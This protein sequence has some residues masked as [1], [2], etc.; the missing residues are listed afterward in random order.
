MSLYVPPQPEPVAV[1]S[2]TVIPLV[3]AAGHVLPPERLFPDLPDAELTRLLTAEGTSEPMAVTGFAILGAD[4][5]ILVDTC[6]GGGKQGRK[7]PFP[8]FTSRWMDTL[9]EAGIAPDAV[10][11]VVNTHLH[12]DHV[13]WN[14]TDELKPT[15]PNARYLL[16][17]AEYEH[18]GT[19]RLRHAD[20]VREC[21]TPVAE[22]GLLHLI[23]GVHEIDDG[24]RLLPA[25][26]TLP[27]TSSRRSPTAAEPRSSR[28]T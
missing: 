23:S 11:V 24:V 25:P 26:G 16:A 10:D 9:A 21:V 6:L 12:H 27:A 5:T 20:R 28:G 19:G 18:L 15:F 8:G 14:T 22:A 13:G 3:D 17:E 1:G 4:T 2:R 7:G